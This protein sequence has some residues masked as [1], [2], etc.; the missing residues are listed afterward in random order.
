MDHFP[1]FL[2]YFPDTTVALEHALRTLLEDPERRALWETASALLHQQHDPVRDWEPQ[3]QEQYDTTIDQ[4]ILTIPSDSDL[5]FCLGL[6]AYLRDW[7][8]ER[9]YGEAWEVPSPPYGG[10]MLRCAP[11]NWI[12]LTPYLN[13]VNYWDEKTTQPHRNQVDAYVKQVKDLHTDGTRTPDMDEISFRVY[14]WDAYQK[15]L[16]TEKRPSKTQVAAELL[17]NLRTFK[18]NR[19][20]YNMPFPP[21]PPY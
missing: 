3:L 4:L 5:W 13:P 20:R 7:L 11:G 16:K 18:R 17:M 1:F 9:M 15:L 19:D 10:K 21:L 14:Y 8:V 2:A 12:I 6:E